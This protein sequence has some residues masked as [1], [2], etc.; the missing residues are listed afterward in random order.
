MQPT[1]EEQILQS[2]K[3]IETMLAGFQPGKRKPAWV[4]ST[5]I[6]ALTGWDR[7]KMRTMRNNGVVKTRKV[8]KRYE[9]DASSIPPM[10][11][12]NPII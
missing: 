1:I 2:L 3:R 10:F 5:F 8:G 9:Y 6:S 11:I 12:R 7:E 4:R